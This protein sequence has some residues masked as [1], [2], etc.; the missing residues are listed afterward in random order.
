LS[1]D[2]LPY[3]VLQISRK[4]RLEDTDRLIYYVYTK[5]GPKRLTRMLQAFSSVARF[6]FGMT[7]PYSRPSSACSSRRQSHIVRHPSD[8]FLTGRRVSYGP[9]STD[10][11][12]GRPM[13]ASD[14]EAGTSAGG[15]RSDDDAASFGDEAH[16]L[17][18][19]SRRIRGQRHRRVAYFI[20]PS[21]VRK[22]S[23]S[24]STTY[25]LH[26]SSSAL[27]SDVVRE[28]GFVYRGRS[29]LTPVMRH[30][31]GYRRVVLDRIAGR[32]VV[33]DS[34]ESSSS[35]D[36]IGV[37][38]MWND[39]PDFE[40]RHS[41]GSGGGSSRGGRRRRDGG[42]DRRFS[43]WSSDGEPSGACRQNTSAD[44]RQSGAGATAARGRDEQREDS[45][46]GVRR[47]FC[48]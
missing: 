1:V 24:D 2:H 13:A 15:L 29:G 26:H 14:T 7:L 46:E 40:V 45:A 47:V 4:V 22:R 6:S 18:A 3:S 16:E 41:S 11:R 44:R 39:C 27:M 43:N 20:S 33:R 8:G 17:S 10:Q 48:V 12:S 5:T 9:D 35:V 25:F 36:S 38:V 23:N 31:P 19:V 30:R 32:I 42:D 37:N 28:G 21:S 34:P